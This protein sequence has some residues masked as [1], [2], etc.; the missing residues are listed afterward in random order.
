MS[1]LPPLLF[2]LSE[3]PSLPSPQPWTP[4][5]RPSGLPSP[6]FGFRQPA[7]VS[8]AGSVYRPLLFSRTPLVL[9]SSHVPGSALVTYVVPFSLLYNWDSDTEKL[10]NLLK[11]IDPKCTRAWSWLQAA[12]FPSTL[13]ITKKTERPPKFPKLY[14]SFPHFLNPER[15]VL[16]L[17]PR[18]LS[19]LSK[20]TSPAFSDGKTWTIYNITRVSVF[21]YT[22]F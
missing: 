3:P 1:V 22:F 8:P 18:V 11:V 9:V 10:R 15:V 20:N 5:L 13:H 17:Q 12:C 19:D 16:F 2:W 14:L 6:C 4:L 21:L 7:W